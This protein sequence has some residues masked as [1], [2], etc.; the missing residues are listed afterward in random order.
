MTTQKTGGQNEDLDILERMTRELRS[1]GEDAKLEH[2]GGG[3]YCIRLASGGE[4]WMYWGTSADVWGCDI[5]EGEEHVDFAFL[6][7]VPVSADNVDEAARAILEFTN[8]RRWPDHLNEREP[9]TDVERI[10]EGL[11]EYGIRVENQG[12]DAVSARLKPGDRMRLPQSE[13]EV[14]AH[15]NGDVSLLVEGAQVWRGP[16]GDIKDIRTYRSIEETLCAVAVNGTIVW[17][18]PPDE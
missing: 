18:R 8:G 12:D 11:R 1:R 17:E 10:S 15:E 3:I 9:R 7:G 16:V 5:Y 14:E 6:D 13:L 2:T 4:E